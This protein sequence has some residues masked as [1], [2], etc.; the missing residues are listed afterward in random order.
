[1]PSAFLGCLW[2]L[3]AIFLVSLALAE[4]EAPAS[5]P[6]DPKPKPVIECGQKKVDTFT[7]H[8]SVSS[9]ER[10]CQGK[11][12]RETKKAC[13]SDNSP[14]LV[15]GS[16]KEWW[17]GLCTGDPDKG[18]GWCGKGCHGVFTLDD[19]S[20]SLTP[21]KEPC[22]ADDRSHGGIG[23]CVEVVEFKSLEGKDSS[24]ICTAYNQVKFTCNCVPNDSVSAADSVEAMIS[25][26]FSQL[27]VDISAT[28]KET[29]ADPVMV[30][31]LSFIE[32]LTQ[33]R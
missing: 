2:T 8:A 21:K 7:C 28:G 3:Q 10:D 19:G 26:F 30:M 4:G 29:A 24:Y 1:M 20:D 16:G 25:T 27:E 12:I 6:A 32:E 33:E 15:N 17:E 11:A 31:P 14:S 23:G 22:K 13:K 9:D 5:R 18:K